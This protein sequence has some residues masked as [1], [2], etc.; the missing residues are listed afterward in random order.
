MPVSLPQC[1]LLKIPISDF[2]LAYIKIKLMEPIPSEC[3][4]ILSGN[5]MAEKT[6]R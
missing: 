1:L 5:V 6:S 2:L 4:A 3:H